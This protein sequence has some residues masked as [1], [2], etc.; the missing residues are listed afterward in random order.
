MRPTVLQA[1]ERWSIPKNEG[2]RTT[3]WEML[4]R[5]SIRYNKAAQDILKSFELL[6]SIQTSISA[7]IPCPKTGRRM[8]ERHVAQGHH[9][10]HEQ[11][12]LVD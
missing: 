8:R 3:T 1:D 5:R 2:F 12:D 4:D 7:T 10:R 6:S 11:R 9:G